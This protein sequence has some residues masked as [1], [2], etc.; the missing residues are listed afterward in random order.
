MEYEI[1][2]IDALGRI[3]K[4]RTNN[5]ELFT[6]NLL[7]VIHPYNNLITPSEIKRIGFNCIFTNAYILYQNEISRF[8][9]L[10]KG[11]HQYLNYDGL[12]AT[13][14]GAFQQYMYN[15]D[16]IQI[17]SN[18]IEKF[19]E[20]IGSDFPVILDLPVQPEDDLKI[21]QDKVNIS[22]LRA[23]ENIK[24]RSKECS[25]IGP[26]HGSEFPELLKKSTIEMSKLNFGIYAI[27]G[28]VKYFLNYQF[29]TILK[30]LITVKKNIIPTKPLHMFGLGLPQ[31][32][33]LAVAFGSDIM[34]SAAYILYAK[35]N[36]Y[37]SLSTGTRN[38][39]EMEEFPCNCPVC[40]NYTP[41]ELQKSE[42]EFRTKQLALHNL[43][44]SSQELK[45]IRQAIREG[46]LWELVE[47]RIRTH[48]YLVKAF[49]LLKKNHQ[50]FEKY[51][52]SYKKH[53]RLFNSSESKFRPII[54]RYNW[55]LHEFYRVPKN[56]NFLIILPELDIKGIKSPSICN[57]IEKINHNSTITRSLIHI[58]FYSGIFGIIPLELNTVFPM[59]QY[60]SINHWEFY[61]NSYSNI[62][63]YFNKNIKNYK[64]CAFLIP[65]TYINQYSKTVSFKER[66]L[67]KTI[68][69]LK[70]KYN[71]PMESF[72]LIDEILEFFKDK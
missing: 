21:A 41:I 9:A 59:G 58:V 14:S 15:N 7:P 44:I 4:L 25:W 22:L 47:Q 32:F 18:D 30:I 13:D 48:P 36:R 57:W 68:E 64:K 12:I 50:F 53:G 26:I 11:I 16:D 67:L 71:I 54:Y 31:F 1:L 39:E 69:K 46:R 63:K 66:N 65:K 6:P 8:E 24:R 27:G 10:K 5:K 55:R 33:S 19:Q 40:N 28:L 45:T 70:F 60:E 17:S 23:N 42:K 38:I 29:R 56:A 49:K 34:D 3:G 20:D 43:Y 35:E 52:K 62:K 61:K 72:D 37:F 51:E 2:D